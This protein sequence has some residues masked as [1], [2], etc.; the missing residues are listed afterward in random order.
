[1]AADSPEAVKKS[2]KLYSLVGLALFIGTALT[3]AVAVF[4]PFD[5]GA[6]GFSTADLVVGLLIASCKASL[7]M[8]F[9]MHLNG[10][11]KLIYLIYGMAIVFALF[12]Y[13][14]TSLGFADPIEYL[15]FFKGEAA[16]ASNGH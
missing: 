12:L 11:K 8:W 6:R 3:V 16:A 10:E 2:L 4:E 9:F 14:L 13:F 7:V 5:L 15:G 1:M